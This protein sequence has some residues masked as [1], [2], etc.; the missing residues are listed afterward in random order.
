MKR[1]VLLISL[2]SFICLAKSQTDNLQELLNRKQYNQVITLASQFSVADSS[3]SQTMYLVGEASEGLMKYRDAYCYYQHCLSIDS[4]RVDFLNAAA[5][6]ATYL[7][8]LKDAESYYLKVWEADTT[9]FYA[10]IQVARYYAQIGNYIEAVK[11][12]EYLLE[13]DP[14]NS[15][16]LRAVGDCYLRMDSR[17]LAVEAYWSAFQS[18]KENV[19][20]AS[21]LVNT[22]ISVRKDNEGIESMMGGITSLVGGVLPFESLIDVALDVC[23]TA[24]FYNPG[25]PTILQY[26][27]ATLFSAQNYQVSDSI[28]SFLLSQGD[29]SH[30]N[31]KYA[32][33]S[34]Y[35][36]RKYLEAA[37][38][39]DIAFKQDSMAIDV[40]LLLGS[41]LTRSYDPKRA[42]QLFN[43]AEKLMQPEP[44]YVNLLSQFRGDAY[45]RAD[46]IPEAYQVWL[47]SKQSDLLVSIYNRIGLIDLN[48]ITDDDA[49]CRSLFINVLMAKEQARFQNNPESFGFV[50]SRLQQ[51]K[52]EMLR[53]NMKEYSMIAPDNKRST[54]TVEQLDELIQQLSKK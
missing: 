16:I 26:K 11:Y 24:L 6:M 19:S 46:R 15:A 31:I 40:C 21:S 17:F 37:D 1:I 43:W 47:T 4:T 36:T 48:R 30:F 25:N 54:I 18:N 44:V 51:I 23:D 20:L 8:L 7:G 32:G 22:I 35:Y 12:Y 9:D 42:L 28:F 3:D 10:N 53:K 38:L 14:N 49:R 41:A 27:G 29:S 34:K 52:E 13:T 5:R 33:C 50:R 45:V 2:L 39:L